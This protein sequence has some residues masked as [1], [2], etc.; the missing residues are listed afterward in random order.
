MSQRRLHRTAVAIL[1]GATLYVAEGSFATV[2]AQVVTAITPDGTLGTNVTETL[3]GFYNIDGG[4]II[5]GTNQFHSFAQFNVGT[6]NAANFD[7][8]AGIQNVLSRVT[9][10]SISQIDG[11]VSSSIPGANVFLMNPSGVIFGPNSALDVQGAFHATT[12]DYIGLAD[13]ARFNA[14]PSGADAFLTSAPPAAFGFLSSSP[15]PINVTTPFLLQVPAGET[16]SFIGGDVTLGAPDGSAPAYVMAPGGTVNI[17]SAASPGEVGFDGTIDTDSFAQLGDI[18]LVGGSVIDAKQV[19]IRGGRFV[20][21]ESV[22]LPSAFYFFGL[23]PPPDGGVVDIKARNDVIMTGTG[24]EPVTAAPPGILTFSGDFDISAVAGPAKVPDITIEANSV[25]LSGFATVQTDRL[26]P[27]GAPSVVITADMVTVENG[28]AI[29]LFNFF[30][31]PGG[32]MS[33][34]AN[35]IEL[36][37]GEVFGGPAGATGLLAQGVFHPGYFTAAIDPPLSFSDS[38]TINVTAT[39]TLSISGGAQITTDSRSFGRSNDI[40][41]NSGNILLSDPGGQIA[42]QSLFAGDSGNVVLQAAG[43]GQIDIDNGFVVSAST[44]GTGNSG[45]VNISATQAVNISGSASG[46]ASQ[47]V[48]PPE[49]ELNAFAGL[50]LGDPS[51]TFGDLAGALGLDPST[52]DLFD[53]LGA[54][55]GLELTAIP[56]PL[57]P[58]DGGNITVTTPVLTASGQD[59]AIDSSTAWDGNAGAVN[60]GVGALTV[61][62][63]AQIR[64]RSGLV[65]IGTDILFVG[66]GNAGTINVSANQG[67][68]TITGANSQVST[69]TFG[70]GAGGNISLSS[71]ADIVISDDGSVQASSSGSGNGGTVNLSAIEVAIQNGGS[72]DANASD[73]GLA[74]NI[75]INVSDRVV[76]DGGEISTRAVTSDGGNIVILAPTLLDMLNSQITTSVES[77]VGTGGNINIDPLAVVLQN[78]KIIADA[79]GGSGGNISIVAGQFIIDVSS[80]VSASSAL[81]LDGRIEINAPDTNITGQLVPLPKNFLDASKL[82]SGRCEAT[83]GGTSSLAARGQGGVPPGPDGYLPSYAAAD[84]GEQ[85]GATAVRENRHQRNYGPLLAMSATRCVW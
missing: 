10:G 72:V 14:I 32:T 56:E 58:G 35:N 71:V 26:G 36:S 8:P 34:N 17:A 3:P 78:S 11:L 4:T 31:G 29:A 74:G 76:L 67:N 52:A 69:A 73:T 18:S 21:D 49:S 5:G 70:A 39:D 53:V 81:G 25:T 46:I 85:G 64:S 7:G 2:R 42:S 61:S 82:L 38:G 12:G 44:F 59:S 57:V 66:D 27:G 30:E 77:G 50:I 48:P 40:T 65:P 43:S 33:I 41:I 15:G 80:I 16:L 60:L 1:V 75:N 84:A 22:I 79:F 51:A 63:G 28:A 13:G 47:T 45:N 6:G 24:P 83:R 23:S 55:N 9:G 68:I 20:I 19:V 54:L 37:G 62:D